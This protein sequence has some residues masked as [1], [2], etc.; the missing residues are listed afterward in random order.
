MLS[1]DL[2]A[3]YPV[4][5][6]EWQAEGA[7]GALLIHCA[8]AS[9][10]AWGALAEHLAGDLAM[11]AFDLPGHGRS[12]E[13]LGKGDYHAISTAIAGTFCSPPRHVIGHSLGATI[14]LRLAQERPELV[15][16]LVLIEPVLFAAA[17]GA[18][19]FDEEETAMRP[20]V[21]A[22]ER[23]DHEAAARAFTRRW[24]GGLPWEALPVAQ[25]EYMIARI[26]LIPATRAVLYEDASV[27]RWKRG[28]R[29]CAGASSQGRGTCCRSPMRRRWRGKYGRSSLGDG[30]KRGLPS[31]FRPPPRTPG[32][33][34]DQ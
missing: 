16:S 15:R 11:Q 17:R 1:H 5:W 7:P 9:A 31:F 29:G 22:M 18:A 32:I 19:G 13:W 30:M 3:G 8:L 33:F 20:F 27:P 28:Y 25:R 2:R 10:A 14:A 4:H 21:E 23:G 12:G 24:G 26:G 6:R 34:A